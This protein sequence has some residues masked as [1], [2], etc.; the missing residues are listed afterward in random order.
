LEK[1][2]ETDSVS[3]RHLGKSTPALRA[4]AN[5]ENITMNFFDT[6]QSRLWKSKSFRPFPDFFPETPGL[7]V[8]AENVRA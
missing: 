5:R 8:T 4:T 3:H 1:G 6:V 2:K 7:W